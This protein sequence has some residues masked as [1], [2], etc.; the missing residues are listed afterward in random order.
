LIL[1]PYL[2]SAILISGIQSPKEHLAARFQGGSVS[3]EEFYLELAR[4]HRGKPLGQEA[5]QFLVDQK[6]VEIEAKA[7]NLRIPQEA[8][9][10]RIRIVKKQLESNGKDFQ[11]YLK[12]RGL[13]P[14]AF[15]NYI[16]L[17]LLN[18]TLV[19]QD[20]HFAPQD[21][22][23]PAQIQVWRREKSRKHKVISAPSQ[24]PP[25]ISAKIG[26]IEFT[27]TDLGRVMARNL[28]RRD[29]E[30]ILQQMVAA[31][32]LRL[33]GEK[34]KIHL[35][36]TDLDQELNRR[37]Q[38]A[39]SNPQYKKAKIGFLDILK[40][41]GRTVDDLKEG[42]A[43]QAQLLAAHLGQALFPPEFLEKEWKTNKELWMERLGPSRRLMKIDILGPPKRSLEEARSRIEKIRKAAKDPRSFRMLA[44]QYSEDPR[45][46]KLAGDFGFVHRKDEGFSPK[47][48]A[49]SFE[50]PT[51]QVS[52]PIES[53]G[54]VSILMVTALKKAPKESQMLNEIRAWLFR[55]W[56][57]KKIKEAKVEFLPFA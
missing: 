53:K 10:A 50:L 19:R 56:L 48:L 23:S 26:P 13:S 28:V 55:N 35:T 15:R 40:A 4:R 25:G 3:W 51:G 14:E 52:E 47:V 46:K 45:G 18:E 7:R 11:G 8:V 44:R 36:K 37:I 38:E 41:Q 1:L 31:K 21:P 29:R 9:D 5:L 24:L 16:Q 43:F 49:R 12:K 22:I 27:L 17:S 39:S 57:R 42:T 34:K 32:I 6:L 20:L 33:E 2:F 54:K 30:S